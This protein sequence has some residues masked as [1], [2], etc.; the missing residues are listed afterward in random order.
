MSDISALPPPIVTARL[1]LHRFTLEDAAFIFELVNDPAFVR[2]IGD[3]GVRT[4]DDARKYLLNGPLASYAE[5]GFGLCKVVRR[6]DGA[7]VGMC[8]LL[9]RDTLED[10]DI[11]YAFLPAYW[12]HGYAREAVSAVLE[13]GRAA[14]R[15]ARVVAITDPANAASIRVL[16]QAGF[17]FER[18]IQLTPDATPLSLFGRSLRP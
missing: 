18:T 12:G 6:S 8:G 1:N 5:Q 4:L 10:V 13:Y 17:T 2:F 14:L 3:K 16:E 11:G 15:L 7:A 9:K